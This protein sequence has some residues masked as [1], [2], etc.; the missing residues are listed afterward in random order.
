MNKN[1]IAALAHGSIFFL[2]VILPLILLIVSQDYFVNQEAK[3]ALVM[4]ILIVVL[5]FVGP[6]LLFL[7]YLL[8]FIW[9][10]Q[11]IIA[12]FTTLGGSSS[13][14]LFVYK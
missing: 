10:I 4:H 11:S 3:K 14:F 13:R 8:A 5:F 12:I 1:A 9:F 7:P 6:F 2:P